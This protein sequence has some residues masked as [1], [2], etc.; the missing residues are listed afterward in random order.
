LADKFR[1]LLVL[2]ESAMGLGL[3]LAI[4]SR[5]VVFPAT[6]GGTT[7]GRLVEIGICGGIGLNVLC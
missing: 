7:K 1:S 6:A 5:W 4:E 2:R 3:T